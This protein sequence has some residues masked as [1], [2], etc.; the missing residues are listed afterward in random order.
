M[1]ARPTLTITARYVWELV[2]DYDNSGNSGEIVHSYEYTTSGSYTSTTFN[3]TVTEEARK[4]VESGSIQLQSGASYG[5]VSASVEAGFSTSTEVNN[6]LQYTTKEQ[7]EETTTWSIKETRQYTIGAHSRLILYQRHFYG[8]GMS[9][10][11]SALRTTSVPL[12]A[13]EIE[14]EVLIDL[15]LEARNYISG[16]TVVYAD[17]ASH[18]PS[19]RVRDWFGGS[20][21]INFGFEGKFVWLVPV[22]T[23]QVSEALTNFD[24]VIQ[25]QDDPRYDDLAAGTGG[26]FRYLLPVRQNNQYLF[27]SKLT[28]VRSDSSLGDLSNVTWPG[29]PQGATRDINAGRDGTYLYL[30]WQLQRAYAL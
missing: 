30:S 25:V 28:L 24:L 5:P 3:E 21:D 11:D 15:E 22:Y 29:L 9:V 20:D 7:S 26:S 16:M 4:L 27:I 19:D 1:S 13:D 12:P 18:A 8:P 10:Q 6:M 2:F 14:E 23:P 17:Q